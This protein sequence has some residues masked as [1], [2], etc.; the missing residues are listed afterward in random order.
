MAVF[1]E[2]DNVTVEELSEFS[3]AGLKAIASRGTIG[4]GAVQ[5]EAVALIKKDG[6]EVVFAGKY[7]GGFEDIC[8]DNGIQTVEVKAKDMEDLLHTFA[9]KDTELYIIDTDEGT[10]KVKA[11]SGSLSKSYLL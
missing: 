11:V 2:Q 1:F 6:I 5:E 7:A 8:R 10:R 9:D 3:Y 4:E